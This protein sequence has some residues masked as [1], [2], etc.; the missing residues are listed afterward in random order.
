MRGSLSEQKLQEIGALLPELDDRF[1]LAA[2][3]DPIVDL[4]D[5]D[6]AG[7]L[8][9]SLACLN[10]AGYRLQEVRLGL[11]ECYACLA[12]Y[13]EETPQHD[14]FEAVLTSKF[15]VDHIAMLLYA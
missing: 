8:G 4:Y 6:H 12:W 3:P 15:Y 1:P 10:D 5:L 11:Y 7:H 14:E 9:P 2:F 13:W